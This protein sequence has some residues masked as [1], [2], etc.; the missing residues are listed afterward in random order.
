[1]D[2]RALAVTRDRPSGRSRG[3]AAARATL[4]ALE[5]TST[6]RAAG[7]S[8]MESPLIDD[9]SA[10]TKKARAAI[11]TAI[12]QRRPWLKRSSTGPISG[13][14]TANGSNVSPRN[15]ETCPRASPVGIWKNSVPASEIA[16]AASAAAFRAPSSISR[17]RPLESAPSAAAARRAERNAK[18][19]NRPVPRATDASPRPVPFTPEVMESM[20][21]LRSDPSGKLMTPVCTS[22]VR[23]GVQAG[24]FAVPARDRSSWAP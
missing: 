2:I 15:S 8:Q 19:L 22:T 13:A 21:V 3:T 9:A 11:V 6:P 4:Y 24:P 12:A 20:A 14:T 17:A 16:T 1:M 18:R 5:P 10:H 23:Q 7:N